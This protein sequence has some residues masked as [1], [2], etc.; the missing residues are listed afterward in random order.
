MH[1][2]SLSLLVCCLAAGSGLHAQETRQPDSLKAFTQKVSKAYANAANLSFRVK[3]LYANANRPTDYLDSVLGSV[4]MSQGHSRIVMG[5]METVFTDKFAIR[6]LPDDKLIYLS[7]P[8]RV[9]T[10]NPVGMLDSILAHMTDLD[11]RLYRQQGED[12]LILKFPSG[13]PYSQMVIHVDDKSGFFRRIDYTVN[14][15]ELV[16]REMVASP[17]HPAPYESSG[18]VYVLFSDYQK[19]HLDDRIFSAD[20]FFTKEAGKYT[21]S[22]RFKDYRIFLASSNL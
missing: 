3:Y 17:D 14:A 16:G 2:L 10:Q 9:E 19:G 11:A 18:R 15:A 12:V 6:V 8:A 7:A 5:G 13:A 4:E 21:P 20:N 1:H 22:S